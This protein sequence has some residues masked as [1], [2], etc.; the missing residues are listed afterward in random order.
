MKNKNLLKQNLIILDKLYIVPKR[1][2][3]KVAI[4]CQQFKSLKYEILNSLF[5]IFN[6][7]FETKDDKI[8]AKNI[9]ENEERVKNYLVKLL[10]H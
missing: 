8:S 1:N 9:N 4:K 3:E 10:K 2:I 7:I 5:E 6:Y